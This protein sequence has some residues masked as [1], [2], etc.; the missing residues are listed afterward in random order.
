VALAIALATS[1]CSLVFVRRVPVDARAPAPVACSTS[2]V[3]PLLDTV[4][5]GVALGG[6]AAGMVTPACDSASGCG[7]SLREGLAATALVAATLCTASAVFGYVNAGRCEDVRTPVAVDR[8]RGE[9]RFA[10]PR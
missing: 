3:A 8:A 6:A 1:G 9:E 10:D 5:A 2:R 4:C 7:T